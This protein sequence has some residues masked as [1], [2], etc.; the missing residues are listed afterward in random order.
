MDLSSIHMPYILASY[1]LVLVV[2][3]ILSVWVVKQDR[4]VRQQLS[5]LT[6]NAP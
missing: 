6:S 2:F 4:N 3:A 5:K 1:M